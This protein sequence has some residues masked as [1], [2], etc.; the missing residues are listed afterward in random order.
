M[1]SFSWGT[2][3]VPPLPAGEK[4]PKG[5]SKGKLLTVREGEPTAGFQVH[6]EKKAG[7]VAVCG[8]GIL[9]SFRVHPLC[10][11][12]PAELPTF[13]DGAPPRQLFTEVQKLEAAYGAH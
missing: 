3:G 11:L 8:A 7:E 9:G 5:S 13:A 6:L 1:G 10:G 12:G 2:G 4:H